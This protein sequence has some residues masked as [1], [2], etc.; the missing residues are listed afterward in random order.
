M[1]RLVFVLVFCP[2]L[3]PGRPTQAQFVNAAFGQ[4]VKL[5]EREKSGAD[6]H[7]SE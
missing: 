1:K 3:A 6:L 5:Y 2:L 7:A 4:N